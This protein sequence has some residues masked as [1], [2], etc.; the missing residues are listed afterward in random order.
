MRFS[1]SNQ[2]NKITSIGDGELPS[3]L[4]DIKS[5]GNPIA[6]IG[7]HAFDG[8]KDSLINLRIDGSTLTDLP[9]ALNVLQALSYCGFRYGKMKNIPAGPELLP[10]VAFLDLAGNEISDITNIDRFKYSLLTRLDLHHN[11]ISDITPIGELQYVRTLN[12]Y[13][14]K[15][16]D[17]NQVNTA[18][19]PHQDS[20]Q[21]LQLGANCMTKI[22]DVSTLTQLWRLGLSSN[23]IDDCTS[24]AIPDTLQ[25]LNIGNNLLPCVPTV[26]QGHPNVTELYLTGNKL[27]TVDNFVFP[28]TLQSLG[29]DNNDIS[30]INRLEFDKSQS[31]LHS[32]SL[33]NNDLKSVS[34][35][36]FDK[37]TNLTSLNLQ[38][39]GLTKL[40]L[41]LKSLSSLTNLN[42]KGDSSLTCTCGEAALSDWYQSASPTVDGQCS[43]SSDVSTFLDQLGS[44]CASVV[45]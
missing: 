33:K 40:P 17:H 25:K 9:N 1:L 2:G 43:G 37:L 31:D 10:N 16:C 11:Q 24:G 20:M 45:G 32:L 7:D 5:S 21:I 35:T 12:L 30:S 6:T 8:S 42:V 14:N 34:D 3:N 41:A 28:S 4:Q 38:N 39:T 44:N 29:L 27:N 23:Q 18:L 22:P 13:D 36:A 26:I 19:I 15:I